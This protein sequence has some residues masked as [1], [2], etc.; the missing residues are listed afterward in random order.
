MDSMQIAKH[1]EE[2]HPTPSLH[3]DSPYLAEVM[4]R[5]AGLQELGTGLRGV[6]L[7]MVPGRLLNEKSVSYWME[8]RT[9]DYGSL[10]KLAED[11]KTSKVWESSAHNAQHVTN[12]LKENNTGPFFMG[13][14]VSY[15]DF[16]WAGYLLFWK[17]IGEDVFEKLMGITGDKQVHLDFLKA[18]EPWSKRDDH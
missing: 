17:R 13:D 2:S 16:C 5:I 18:V 3:L 15:A 14:T 1:I 11:S 4:K 9:K 10:E 12:M 8:T 7:P 6:F